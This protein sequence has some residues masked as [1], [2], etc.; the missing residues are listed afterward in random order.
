MYYLDFIVSCLIVLILNQL[1]TNA[2][3]STE[4]NYHYLNSIANPLMKKYR[5]IHR[6]EM[7]LIQFGLIQCFLI[8]EFMVLAVHR[9][10]FDRIYF[11][12]IQIFSIRLAVVNFYA[13]SLIY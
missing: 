10:Q 7:K 2:V 12:F 4:T 8:L 3:K 9:Y 6:Y 13:E 1:K 5:A 11:H